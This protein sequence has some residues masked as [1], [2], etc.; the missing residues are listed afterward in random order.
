MDFF[1]YRDENQAFA[2]LA[3]HFIG[4]PLRVRVDGP[5]RVI[6][7]MLVSANYFDTLGV[8]ARL[9][10]ALTPADGR[11]RTINAIVLSDVGWR[12][13]FDADPAIVGRTAFIE[14]KPATIVG[15]LP[16]SFTGAFA[17]MLPQIYAPVLETPDINSLAAPG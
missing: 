10:R 9:G 3:A 14:G 13:F 4:G 6:P 12:R 5:A 17:P 7:V 11:S 2:S 1:H 16:A 15:V 8:K